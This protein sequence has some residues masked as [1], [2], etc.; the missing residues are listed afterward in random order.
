[1]LRLESFIEDAQKLFADRAENVMT[2]PAS[3]M[4]RYAPED[5]ESAKERTMQVFEPVLVGVA[6]ASDPIFEG[7]AEPGVIGPSFVKPEGWVEGAKSVVSVFFPFAKDV[8]ISNRHP[9]A[10]SPEWQY[11][12]FQGT[13]IIVGFCQML[14]EELRAAGWEAVMPV[15]S[16]G[17]GMSREDSSFAGDPDFEI[18]SAW[19]ERHA[20]YACGLGTFGLSRG[21]ITRSGMA[22]RFG[23]IV[24]NAPIQP[25]PRDYVDVNEW[26]TFCG[27][28]VRRC[29]V[30][31]ISLTE[32]KGN[33]L[34]EEWLNAIEDGALYGDACGKCQIGVPCS[35]RKPVS[36]KPKP[37]PR[38]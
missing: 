19:S 18:S 2:V 13:K 24:T 21:L 14:C 8:C 22:G 33:A 26:C 29:P 37:R 32:G 20:A 36:L 10:A 27:A 35:T 15:A 28:C 3:M 38:D 11:A 30:G 31:A 9:G 16:E 4:A 1:M 17:F 7:F 25:T 5:P 23:S 12:K 6:D 34:C